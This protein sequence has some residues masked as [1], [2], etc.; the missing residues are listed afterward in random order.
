MIPKENQI[1][2]LDSS[3]MQSMIENDDSEKA[4]QCL[5]IFLDMKKD[6]IHFAAI[7]TMSSF[8]RAISMADGIDQKNLQDL[9]CV[10]KIIPSKADFNDENAVIEEMFKIAEAINKFGEEKKKESSKQ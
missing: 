1:V 10:I 8:L 7:A 4:V 6:N 2:F 5:N 9:I 3:T